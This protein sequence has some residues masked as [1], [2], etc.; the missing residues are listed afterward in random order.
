[1]TTPV[2]NTPIAFV[3]RKHLDIWKNRQ[4]A[5]V[6]SITDTLSPKAMQVFE[7][8]RSQGAQF[9]D[10]LIHK[11][12]L[13]TSQAE[14]V[15]GELISAGIVTSDSFTGL[16]ALLVPDKFKTTA[17]SRR[18]TELFSMNY[19]GRWSLL[20]N[21]TE[22]DVRHDSN[23]ENETIARALLRRY[24]ILFRKLAEKEELAPPWRELV[25][26]LRLLELQGQIRGGRF[27]DGVWGE[28]FALPEAIT[29][30]RQ[31]TKSGKTGT[32]I[33]ISAA[34]PLNLTGVLTPG[35]RVTGYFGNR[36]LYRDGIPVAFREAKEIRFPVEPEKREKWDLQTRLVKRNISPRLRKYLGKGVY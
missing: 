16:R 25:R 12:Q 22:K 9:F 26:V 4:S 7:V 27:I 21:I 34:D 28:Q 18:G 11:T 13:F 5:I 29:E 31:I 20:A 10:D 15:L 3:S 1:M 36:I 30:L 6:Y 33:S 24:G 19:A 35:K 32:L 17:G 2:K 23:E 8:L 14:D